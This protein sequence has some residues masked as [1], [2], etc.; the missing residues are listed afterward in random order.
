MI[1]TDTTWTTTVRAPFGPLQLTSDG[2]AL[3]RLLI[4]A[5]PQDPTWRKDPGPFSQV[6]EELAEY[7]DGERQTFGTPIRLVGTAFQQS[8]W[9]ALR[10]IP[11][12]QTRTYGE[13][14]AAIG[15]PSAV[16][17]VGLANSRNPISILVPCHRVVGSTGALT[18]YS[19]G[20]D[21]KRLLLD[22]ERR[23]VGIGQDS[24]LTSTAANS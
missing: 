20:I 11:Y 21:N 19:G 13:I 15:S 16:R 4:T 12:G 22:L 17:A 23:T 1:T 9:A 6:I 10:D 2:T 7:F 14:A 3:T 8:V 18:G 24:L 5:S